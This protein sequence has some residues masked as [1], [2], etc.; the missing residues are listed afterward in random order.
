[1]NFG[2]INV[3]FVLSVIGNLRI[4]GSLMRNFPRSIMTAVNYIKANGHPNGVVMLVV[5]Y[6]ADLSNF[7]GFREILEQNL[8]RLLLITVYLFFYNCAANYLPESE[9]LHALRDQGI[10]LNAIELSI[11]N[12]TGYSHLSELAQGTGGT[13]TVISNRNEAQTALDNVFWYLNKILNE[14]YKEL[15]KTFRTV[16]KTH[17]FYDYDLK[18]KSFVIVIF[19]M[20]R[21]Y[22]RI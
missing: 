13:Y 11:A 15:R 19:L 12:H 9:V 21:Y 2:A 22:K 5:K 8:H 18:R 20:C 4:N 7:G 10:I 1:M 6:G 16:S 17:T 14:D 3:F